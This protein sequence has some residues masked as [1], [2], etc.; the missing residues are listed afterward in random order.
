MTNTSSDFQ[1][2]KQS[3]NTLLV[4]HKDGYE[5]LLVSREDGTILLADNFSVGQYVVTE[6]PMVEEF[7]TIEL[8]QSTDG[9]ENALTSIY[10]T[11]KLAK[12]NTTVGEFVSELTDSEIEIFKAEEFI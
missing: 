9:T 6:K 10:E 7:N 1:V 4:S 11:S 5:Y 8:N 3:E 2:K 12:V